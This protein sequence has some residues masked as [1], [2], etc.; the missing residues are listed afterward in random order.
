MKLTSLD[1]LRQSY[2]NAKLVDVRHRLNEQDFHDQKTKQLMT[3]IEGASIGVVWVGD[4]KIVL[5]SRT[6]PHK[7]WALPGGKVEAGERFDDA[8][9][10]E[11]EEETGLKAAIQRLLLI[12]RKVFV[13]PGGEELPIILAIYEAEASGQSVVATQDAVEEGIVAQVFD[14]DGLPGEMILQDKDKIRLAMESVR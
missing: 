6:R 14:I 4:G 2:P 10:R 11:I 5:T 12:E 13:S 3:P 7:G 8:F 9:L 1:T